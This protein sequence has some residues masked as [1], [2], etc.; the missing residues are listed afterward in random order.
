MGQTAGVGTKIP[1]ETC[2]PPEHILSLG[3][4]LLYGLLIRLPGPH[5]WKGPLLGLRLCCSCFEILKKKVNM[6]LYIFILQKSS[7]DYVAQFI[8]MAYFRLESSNISD[9]KLEIQI[10]FY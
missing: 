1:T 2:L 3:L 4:A 6:G 9:L 5:Y 10:K 7:A 8:S